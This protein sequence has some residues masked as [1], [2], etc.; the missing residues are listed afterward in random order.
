MPG[1]RLFDSKGAFVVIVYCPWCGKQIFD[2]TG[3]GGMRVRHVS[4]S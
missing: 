4:D 1:I 2:N 3:L